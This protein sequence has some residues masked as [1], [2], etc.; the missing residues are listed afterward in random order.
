MKEDETR[1]KRLYK[2]RDLTAR[3]L[4]MVVG[5]DLYFAD[6]TTFNDPLDCR[7]SLSID[8]NEGE[9]KG[10]ARSLTQLRKHE[11]LNAA[12]K[13][14]RLKGAKSRDFIEKRSHEQADQV[15]AKIEYNAVNPDQD[16][17]SALSRLLGR[18]IEYEL[19][20][21][22]E[23]GVV[24]LAEQSNCPLM[25]SHYGDQHRGICVGYSVPEISRDKVYR[26]EY[27]GS[28]MVKAS[29]VLAM[30]KNDESARD[31]VD[32]AVL[33]QKAANWKYE[34]EWRLIGR[35]GLNK[36][37]LEMEEIIFGMR[38]ES[39]TK[40]AIMKSLEGRERPVEYYEVRSE[41]GTFELRKESL[42]LEDELFFNFPERSLSTLEVFEAMSG[43][44]RS[45]GDA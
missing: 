38:C 34:T 11:E 35:R 36:S 29:D 20:R 6:P 30:L 43:P 42:T 37:P 41:R 23:K 33:L 26:V 22:Y 39:S 1:P 12:A 32:Q 9:L 25:W 45:T 40:Y 19:L 18:Q 7:P 31:R 3:T 24:S 5:D 4:D 2:Y 14:M 28:R 27:G 10:V 8:L 13:T 15:I 44:A 16:A 21:R 17:F